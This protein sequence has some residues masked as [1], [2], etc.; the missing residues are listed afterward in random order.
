[1][2]QRTEAMPVPWIRT[3]LPGPRASAADCDRRAIHVAVVHAGLSAGAS[4]AAM[5]R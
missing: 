3:E 2:S 1:M 5:G 4:S